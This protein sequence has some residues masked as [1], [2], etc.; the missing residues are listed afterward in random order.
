MSGQRYTP[1]FKEEAVKQVTV[2]GH[3]VADVAQRL[4]TTTHSLY[5]WIKRYGPDKVNELK[6]LPRK[7]KLTIRY[8]YLKACIQAKVEHPFWIVKCQFG[9]VKARYKELAKNDS[10]LMML[11]NLANLVG[12]DQLISAQARST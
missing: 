12:V 8:E 3:S 7:N 1:E 5:A 6:K 2:A 9:F 4:G 10:Q 11:F